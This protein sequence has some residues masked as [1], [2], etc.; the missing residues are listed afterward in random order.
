MQKLYYSISEVSKFV[1]EEQHI[2]RYW[3]KEFSQLK[4][5]K[6][7]GGN[8]IYSEKDVQLIK[9][10]KNLLRSEK[11]SLKGAKEQLNKLLNSRTQEELFDRISRNDNALQATTKIK[12]ENKSI[13]NSTINLSKEDVN[14]LYKLLSD[15]KKIL[16]K[17][18]NC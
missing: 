7:R 3:E 8:R 12:K 16:K 15:V 9:I 13:I 6:N 10:I 18:E 4:P 11:L 14:D 17:T 5:R 2:L 1:D